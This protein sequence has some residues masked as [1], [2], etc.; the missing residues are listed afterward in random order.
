VTAV[1]AIATRFSLSFKNVED[2]LKTF[3]NNR[4][5]NVQKWIKGFNEISEII[6]RLLYL[7]WI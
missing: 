5:E 2:L 1:R 3:S 4:K 7:R 6:E